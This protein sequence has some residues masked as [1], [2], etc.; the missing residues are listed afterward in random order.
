MKIMLIYPL[1]RLKKKPGSRWLPLG[2]SFIAAALQK[3]GHIVSIF[4]RFAATAS[5]GP[6]RKK[7]NTHMLQQLQK[8]KPDLVGLNTI[9]PLIYDT[10]E[11][12]A[13]VRRQH[14]GPIIAG[15][16]HATALPEL[17][18]RKI[19]DL[20]G[21]VQGEGEQALTRLAGGEKPLVI[22]GIWWRRGD[23]ISGSSP[24]QIK[25]LD[26]L[27]FPVLDLLDMDFYTRPAK[28]AI[29]AHHLSA[30]SMITSRGCTQR[31]NFCSETLTYGRGVRMHSPEYVVE[32]MQ[33]LA[34]YPVEGLY[35]HDNDF[36]VDKERAITICEKMMK[37]GLHRRFK[38]AI[39][40][41][42]NRLEKEVLRYLKRAGCTL[43]E[44][45]I[46]AA[47]Q[48][49]LDFVNKRTT[50]DQNMHALRLCHREGIAAHA[51]MML[52]FPGET[53]S[54]LEKRYQWLK[55]AGNNFTLSMSMLQLYPGTSLYREKGGL[56]F[57]KKPWTEEAVSAYYQKDHLSSMPPAERDKWYK[58]RFV[59]EMKKRNRLAI[60][61]CNPPHK[62]LKLILSKIRT[63]INLQG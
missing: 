54:D 23:A 22:P 62:I 41:R 57:E 25:D 38:F 11:C 4:D 61:R 35:F 46:E 36:L 19:T 7:I 29:R 20:D 6:D 14:S 47:S 31:C 44:L 28:S 58:K 32:W 18:L 42:V 39:Q 24:E 30:L 16:H 26:S 1:P 63:K 9:S 27:P 3:Q 15:G 56:F 21:L 5:L 51:Y 48:G 8:F 43:I 34:R 13:L 33:T 52:G 17:T 10:V 53:G 55:R 60:L 2:L 40:T 37:A 50:V 49:Q 45:G 12:A 59:P